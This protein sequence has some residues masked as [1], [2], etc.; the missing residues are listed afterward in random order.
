MR[1]RR[2]PTIAAGSIITKILK[3]DPD[4]MTGKVFSLDGSYPKLKAN[5]RFARLHILEM[6]GENFQRVLAAMC[7]IIAY[8]VEEKRGES[9][10]LAILLRKLERME[11]RNVHY[12]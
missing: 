10:P 7:G 8:L 3:H 1:D 2:Q 12:E 4:P 11:P 9:D 6:C 5:I